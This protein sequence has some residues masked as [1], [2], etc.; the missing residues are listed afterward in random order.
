MDRE[1]Q[2]RWRGN[3]RGEKR[4]YRDMKHLR[5]W[6][7]FESDSEELSSRHLT[8]LKVDTRGWRRRPETGKTCQLFESKEAGLTREQVDFLDKCTEGQWKLNPSTGLVDVDGDFSC[9]SMGLETLKG[10]RFGDIGGNFNCRNNRLETLEGAPQEVG[11]HF[12]CSSNRLESLEGAPQKVGGHFYCHSNRLETLE[13][14]PQKVGGDFSCSSNSLKTLEGAPQEVGGD[15]SCSS[16]SLKTLEGAPQ[17]VGG[18]F[19]CDAF[20]L[21]EGEWNPAGWMKVLREGSPDAQ[22]L[23]MPFL[24]P[25]VL[26]QEIRKNPEDMIMKLKSIWNDPEF[27]ETRERLVFPRGYEGEMDLLGTLSDVGL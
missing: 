5:E 9:R 26:N 23:I 8:F 15:F 14:A 1:E 25:E 12:Y 4:I 21:D 18:G 3:Y 10:I 16:N 6:S 7:L 19:Y 17:E 13:G 22:K 20:S 24:T 11:D 27:R 2:S